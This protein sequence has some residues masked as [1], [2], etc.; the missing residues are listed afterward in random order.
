MQNTGNI[1][2]L[3]LKKEHSLPSSSSQYSVVDLSMSISKCVFYNVL[4]DNFINLRCI[5][6]IVQGCFPL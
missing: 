5:F 6:L 2:I 3:F 4:L 1:E